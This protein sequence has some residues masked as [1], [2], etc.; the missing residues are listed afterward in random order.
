MSYGVPVRRE[1]LPSVEAEGTDDEAPE[2]PTDILNV[3]VGERLRFFERVIADLKAQIEERKELGAR[4][5]RLVDQEWCEAKARLFELDI[6]PMGSIRSIDQRR[7][8]IDG[9]LAAL[10]TEKRTEDVACFRDIGLIKRDLREWERRYNDIAR[11]AWV[12]KGAI[13]PPDSSA[14]IFT[15]EGQA[16][17]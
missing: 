8:A 13:Q 2:Q 11:R 3:L 4:L 5:K 17:R 10:E 14:R 16:G 9:E 6:W 15:D 1:Y 7:Q 12:I